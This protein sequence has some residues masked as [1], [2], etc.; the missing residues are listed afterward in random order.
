MGSALA[1]QVG[2]VGSIPKTGPFLSIRSQLESE[3]MEHSLECAGEG[4]LR[5]LEIT[6]TRTLC[7]EELRNFFAVTEASFLDLD[8]IDFFDRKR[9]IISV[10][11]FCGFGGVL[12]VF[13]FPHF[14]YSI[15]RPHCLLHEK[16]RRNSG[17]I[18]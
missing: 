10:L 5:H 9:P 16:P 17:E 1:S 14:G 12:I 15:V 8:V 13:I 11:M 4:L 3:D 6:R 2:E 7:P 18:P